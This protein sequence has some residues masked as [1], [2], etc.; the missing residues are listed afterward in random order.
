MYSVI[1]TFFVDPDAVAGAPSVFITGV[2]LFIKAKPHRTQNSSG[3]DSPGI[4]V[5]LCKMENGVPNPMRSFP[6]V[7]RREYDQVN[8]ID[9]SSIPTA[10]GFPT[11]ISVETGQFYGIVVR[12]D[13]SN[14]LLWENKQGD[15][16]VGTNSPSPGATGARDGALYRADASG[17]NVALNQEADLKFRVKAAKFNTTS[18]DIDLVNKAYEFLTVESRT[19]TF[20]GGEDVFVQG[21]QLAGTVNVGASN[22]AVT[23][24]G[25]T[26][27]G[28]AAGEK[29]LIKSNN[30][31]RVTEVNSVESATAMTLYEPIGVTNAAAQIFRVTTG[32]LAQ[33]DYVTGKLI[34]NDSNANTTA[35]FL[36]GGVIRGASS[37]TTAT[38]TTVD[39]LK[40]DEFVS[41]VNAVTQ[42]VAGI[43]PTYNMAKNP[44]AGVFSI[45]TNY[46][47]LVES[48]QTPVGAEARYIM[49]RSNEVIL[50]TLYGDDKSAVVRLRFSSNNPYSAPFV[51]TSAADITVRKNSIS[52]TSFIGDVDTEVGSNGIAPSKH[53]TTKMTFEEDRQ[54]EDLRVFASA[55]RPAGTNIQVY[56]KIMNAADSEAFDDKLWTRLEIKN[57]RDSIRSSLANPRDFI[58]YEFG[59]P[60]FPEIE[61]KIGSGFIATDGSPVL[62]LPTGAPDV[63]GVVAGR[64]I[65]L[66]NP[67][68]PDNYI[69]ARVVSVTARTITLGEPVTNIN[70]IG[71]GMDV[72]LLR[73]NGTAFTNKQNQN[74]VRYF[75]QSGGF[76]D[77]FQTVQI[78]VVLVADQTHIVPSVDQLEVVGLSA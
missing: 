26:L 74:I 11:P 18:V 75:G 53:F 25:T 78:K 22:N 19:D 15:K 28:I 48:L 14:Y 30:T 43:I 31:Y 20:V 5:M 33:A 66:S 61:S 64:L 23:G 40:V 77:K 35:R 69:V 6:S 12:P 54:A 59:F 52:T 76:Y 16:I 70:V 41:H 72:S 10:F 45:D 58:E 2:D 73:F 57:G 62:T 21:A 3:I 37:N 17:S 63:A 24:T 1:Q 42:S 13:D 27:T 39:N 55:Y 8:A 38:I 71:G 36:G 60:A 67:L 4:N 7:S 51:K 49:S 29:V 56:A 32:K 46:A 65:R 9:D 44:S 68:F 34:L 47:P 50:D